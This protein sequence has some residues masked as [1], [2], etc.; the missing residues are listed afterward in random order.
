[1]TNPQDDN[2]VDTDLTDLA[3]LRRKLQAL[4]AQRIDVAKRASSSAKDYR[5]QLADLTEEITLVV[6]A[7][8]NLEKSV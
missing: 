8:E 7:L 1:M 6:A 3:G 2:V 4:T 5:E